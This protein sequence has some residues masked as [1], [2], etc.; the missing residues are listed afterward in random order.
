MARFIDYGTGS[1][2]VWSPSGTLSLVG[3]SCSG[4]IGNASLSATNASFSSYIGHQV[5]IHQSRGTGAGNIEVNYITGYSAGTLSLLFP[6]GATY[7]DSGNSQ[8]QVIVMPMYSGVNLTSGVTLT[9]FDGNVGGIL[10]ILCSGRVYVNATVNGRGGGYRG[11]TIRSYSKNGGSADSTYTGEGEGGVSVQSG[12]PNGCGGAGGG[13][14]DAGSGGG[15]G[16]HATVGGTGEPGQYS[17]TPGGY[18]V[19][20][21][22]MDYVYFG[23]GGGCGRGESNANCVPSNTYYGGNGGDGGPIFFIIARE[24]YIDNSGYFDGRGNDGENSNGGCEEG[25]GGGG[26][27][28]GGSFWWQGI[29]AF[30]NTDK[31]DLRGGTGGDGTG[32][33][34]ADGGNGAKGRMKLQGCSVS[35]SVASTYVGSTSQTLG[36]FNYCGS[37]AQII[38]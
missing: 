12:S 17:T 3:A 38:E 13:G 36:G 14:G 27:G 19:G 2:G 16:G 32:S 28:A 26:A 35:G 34:D 37:V 9:G 31:I 25:A 15:G 7:T 21:S 11:N 18:A 29:K 23:G 4:T 5:L 6:L 24:L 1:A 10:P 8:A 30:L 22:A 33:F 20:N